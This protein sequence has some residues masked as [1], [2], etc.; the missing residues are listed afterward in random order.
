MHFLMLILLQ[1]KSCTWTLLLLKIRK[2]LITIIIGPIYHTKKVIILTQCH[3]KANIRMY[4]KL[5]LIFIRL[6]CFSC[7][8]CLSCF[9]LIFSDRRMFIFRLI[10]VLYIP[11]PYLLVISLAIISLL[12]ISSV[13]KNWFKGVS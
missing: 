5:I 11:F 6:S 1:V 12:I 10:F 9:S 3:L 4:F 13:L 7:F 8:S 2:L